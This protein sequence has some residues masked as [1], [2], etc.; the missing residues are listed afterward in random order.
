[1]TTAPPT[2]PTVPAVHPGTADA[3]P[4]P[5]T[6]L[7][8]G[9]PA[10]LFVPGWCGD[11]TVF[12]PLVEGCSTYRR[13]LSVDLP[14]HGESPDT[15]DYDG[16]GLADALV[17]TLAG[18]GVERFVPV[19][20]SHA[21]WS[22]LELRRRLGPDRVPAVVLLDW[23][24]LGTPPGFADALAGLQSPGWRDVRAALQELWTAGL[25]LPA[26]GRYVAD[27][28]A[29]GERHWHRAGR[30]IA[31]GF[32]R[33]PVPLEAFARVQPCPV[34]HL[35]AQPAD[36]GFLTAQQAWGRDHDWF[37]VRRLEATS[38]FPMFEV[39]AAMVAAIEEFVGRVA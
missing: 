21:G 33:H 32:A 30:E 31:A 18:A 5:T 6:E 26:L 17:E 3:G 37:S 7:G 35:Y 23:M 11:R 36:P 15:G 24:P 39:P 10:L 1:M 34:L 19:S 27:M 12:D 9:E 8:S 38:H 16:A 4:L 20:L 29:Y 25:D 28:G 22:A 2:S 14:G 13:S